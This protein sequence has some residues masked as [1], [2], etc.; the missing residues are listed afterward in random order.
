MKHILTGL[1]L[2][3]GLLPGISCTSF[4]Q[5]KTH[6][7][8]VASKKL[9]TREVKVNA[10]DR[11]DIQGACNVRFTPT[12]GKQQLE[13]TLPENIEKVMQVKVENGTLI[14]NFSANKQL[15][16]KDDQHPQLRIA[17]PMVSDIVVRGAGDITF[18]SD[19]TTTKQLNFLVQGAGDITMRQVKAGS[20]Q[21]EVAG[22]GDITMQRVKANEVK[23]IVRGAGDVDIAAVEARKAEAIVSGAGDQNWERVQADE[24]YTVLEGAGDISLKGIQTPKLTATLRGLGDIE[25]SGTASQATYRLSGKGDITA[26]GL[27]A[28]RVKAVAHSRVGEITCYAS[29]SIE[30]VGRNARD[31][32]EFE[33]NPRKV[34]YLTADND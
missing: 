18:T 30:V 22:A 5:E 24:L 32:V 13:L 31:V 17:A 34:Q 4:A 29:K 10:F 25:L 26:T 19:V 14:V 6:E 1:A 15:T 27:K 20:L 33:G 7:S 12:E 3:I 11:I 23:M 21:A 9:V 8:L 16:F 2:C 28:Q